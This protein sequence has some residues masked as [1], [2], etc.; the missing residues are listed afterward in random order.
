MIALAVSPTHK[1]GQ[2]IGDVIE[3][4]VRRPFEEVANKHG[5][6]LD[7]RHPRPARSGRS[8]VSWRDNKGNV[9]DLDYVFEAG[10]SETSIGRPKAFIETAYRRYTKHSRNKAQ[11][12][13]GAITPLAE[14]YSDDHPFL[15]AVLA[16]VFT[17]GSLTQ[18]ASHGFGVVYFPFES[19]VEAFK[20]VGIDAYFDEQSE[21]A[22]VLTKV[23]AF[24]K[25]TQ[26]QIDR[27][28]TTI[29]QRHRSDIR[30]FID[31]LEGSLTRSV[32][33][34]FVLA[35]H[36]ESCEAATVADA[37]TFIQAYNERLGSKRFVRYEV[38]VRYTNGDE[39]RATFA[40]KS[41]AIKFLKGVA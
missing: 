7:H 36:G 34:V 32:K 41:E 18:L 35:L 15:G 31:D 12:V 33:S 4:S 10:G 6:Y 3:Q 9:H 13:Q 26:H 19:I 17:E 39:I 2:I 23:Q 22:E 14:T 8:K 27:I 38:S 30:R 37:I 29:Q 11:E 40:A 21:D 1:F 28:I 5:L 24:E 16:G 20:T 25:L